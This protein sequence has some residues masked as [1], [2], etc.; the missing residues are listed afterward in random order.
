MAAADTARIERLQ[1][2]IAAIKELPETVRS[3][4]IVALGAARQASQPREVTA[5]LDEAI[6][7]LERE[8]DAG[9]EAAE[10]A[11]EIRRIRPA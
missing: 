1:N 9:V 7:A 10:L 4:V 6:A 2:R 11:Q 5:S 3:D 8:T